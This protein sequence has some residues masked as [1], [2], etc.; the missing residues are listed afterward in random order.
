MA[1]NDRDCFRVSSVIT[2]ALDHCRRNIY[3]DVL[4]FERVEMF[5]LARAIVAD[6]GSIMF[7][8]T[9]EVGFSIPPE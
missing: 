8:K 2:V 4:W 9:D 5:K 7:E 3:D 6:G 1:C